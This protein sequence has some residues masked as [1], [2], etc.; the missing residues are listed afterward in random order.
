[1][2]LFSVIIP[3]FQR[4][5]LLTRCL[6]RLAPGQQAISF[7]EYEVIVTNDGRA[8][9][10]AMQVREEYPWVVWCKGPGKGPAANRNNG[11]RHASAKWIVFTDDDCLPEKNWLQAYAEAIHQYPHIKVFEG[12]TAAD[13][14]QFSLAET[15][16]VNIKGGMLPSC[17]FLIE[18]K[19]FN[20]LHGFD[21]DYQ[22]NF[23]DMDLH[24]RLKMDNE[25]VHFTSQAKVIHPWRKV[26]RTA[27]KNIFRKQKLGITT[28]I[29]KHP[30][31]LK[32]FNSIHF[33]RESVKNFL[34]NSVPR[35]VAFKGSGAWY[36][37]RLRR[38][39]IEMGLKLFP[40]TCKHFARK[41][42]GADRERHKN[43]TV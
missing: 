25:P 39:E 5:N 22:F 34:F 15:A 4:W 2:L 36:E 18:K 38:F 19:L 13:R 14:K 10:T 17:N 43:R 8:D 27:V 29:R 30:E 6:D 26:C 28:F 40:A 32:N 7:L 37:W 42:Q 23:E 41:L 31:V 33:F 1:M 9:E 20:S 24:Y 16:P 12:F 11:V 21:E 35:T 3:T